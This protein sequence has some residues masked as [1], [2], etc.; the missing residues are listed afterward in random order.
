M[1]F[2]WKSCNQYVC[3]LVITHISSHPDD[4]HWL[5]FATQ[6]A[7]TLSANTSII[8]CPAPIISLWYYGS[9]SLRIVDALSCLSH[10]SQIRLGWRDIKHKIRSLCCMSP[11]MFPPRVYI[12]QSRMMW[13]VIGDALRI[14]PRDTSSAKNYIAFRWSLSFECIRTPLQKLIWTYWL[15]E[16]LELLYPICCV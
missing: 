8:A 11:G 6:L 9:V 13:D 10:H 15:C 7:S 16:L 4:D 3:C 14:P 1:C 5:L 12:D 2:C